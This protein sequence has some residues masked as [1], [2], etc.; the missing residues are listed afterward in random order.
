MFFSADPDAVL[1]NDNRLYGLDISGNTFKNLKY[2]A[3]NIQT[4]VKNTIGHP[5]YVRNNQ[6]ENIGAIDTPNINAVQLHWVDGMEIYGNTIKNVLTS[7]AD[8]E[9]IILDWHDQASAETTC[10]AGNKVY[11]N[12][13][14]GCKSGAVSAGVSVWC[15]RDNFIYRNIILD[16]ASGIRVSQ[17][18][19]TGNAIFNNL[20]GHNTYGMRLDDPD[21]Y[22]AP[23]TAITNN[24][25]SGNEYGIFAH[26]NSLAPAETYNIYSGNSAYIIVNGQWYSIDTTSS[27][28][29]D[30]KLQPETY[31]PQDGSPVI[32]AGTNDLPLAVPAD[33]YGHP[34]IGTVDIG[35]VEYQP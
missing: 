28:S 15:G 9:G 14:A 27:T 29:T 20:V 11:N 34:I 24:I 16:N 10:S 5:S 3:I 2:S 8:G 26:N 21:N 17:R 23:V 13:I 1:A 12:Y 25:I 6:I 7:V 32:D 18:Y 35:P 31:I 4:G 19:S 30:L 33:Y 22:G